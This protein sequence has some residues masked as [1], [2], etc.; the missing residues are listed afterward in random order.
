MLFSVPNFTFA[1][2]T[3]EKGKYSK[4]V[5]KLY[6]LYKSNKQFKETLDKAMRN[7]LPP[8]KG[9]EDDPGNP[10]EKF[11]WQGKTIKD[12]LDFFEGWLTFIPGPKNSMAYYNLLYCL[13]EDN[14]YALFFVETEPGLSWT[15]EFVEARGK[16]MESEKSITKENMDEWK[17]AL[18]PAWYEFKIPEGGYKS[19][20]QFFTRELKE[21]RPV[22]GEE[23][24]LAAPADIIVN[25]INANLSCKTKI[26]TK[27]KE[28]LNIEELLN[29]SKFSSKFIGGTAVA[30]ALLTT[31][32]HHFHAPVSGMVVESEERV[33]GGYF[34]MGGEAFTYANN[35]NVAGN[36]STFGIFGTYR[37]GY[38]IIKTKKYGH[39]GMIPV[40]LDDVSSVVFEDPYKTIESSKP[41]AVKKGQKLGHFAFGGSLIIL[42][43]EEGVLPGI[44]V[45][46]GQNICPLK[47]KK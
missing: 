21:P 29:G 35:G 17:K 46:Q 2:E 3:I 34:G 23:D 13:C 44:K 14:D 42:L 38:F 11:C 39:I 12:L 32:Y 16:F 33:N 24:R 8:P 19:F 36:K 1:E 20:Q 43:F 31:V 47:E 4:V 5:W 30:C 9:C 7:V 45:F 37:R 28:T 27:Y 6:E 40:G 41:I 25:M 18:G 10:G 15:R 26:Q 22:V